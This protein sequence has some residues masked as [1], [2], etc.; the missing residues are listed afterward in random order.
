MNE[1]KIVA[2][3]Q[4]KVGECH[5]KEV[6][7][8]ENSFYDRIEIN[9]VLD[10]VPDRPVWFNRILDKIKYEGMI[11][12]T[13]LDI[14]EVAKQIYFNRLNV[15]HANSLLNTNKFSFSSLENTIK[16]LT[17][18]GFVP[19]TKRIIEISYFIEATRTP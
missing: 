13:G 5:L 17:D 4:P 18:R 9:D 1:I 15:E 16:H 6:D 19:N 2:S 3:N 8:L 7:S 11:S 14:I 10:M 12:L